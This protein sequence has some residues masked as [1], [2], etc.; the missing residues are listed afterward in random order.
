LEREEL[1]YKVFLSLLVSLAV[2]IH[3][4]EAAIPTPFPAIKFGFANIITLS[5][6]V[7]FGL[8]AG[9]TLTISRVF[10][11]TL[12]T[13]TFLTPAFFL[14][15]SGGIA[16]TVV[17]AMA[18]R[19]FHPRLSII[20]VSVLG[21]FIHT[22]VQVVVAYLL[23]IKHFQIFLLMPIFLSFSL[24]AGLISG[25]GADFLVRHLEEVPN[26]RKMAAQR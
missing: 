20:G 16:S 24:V 1:R 21:A 9:L 15:M 17:L 14:S 3:T 13:G 22:F 8:R 4:V 2:V 10:I 7:I 19:F 23:F 18:Y 11:G 5:V 26:I 12:L 25:L 6:I